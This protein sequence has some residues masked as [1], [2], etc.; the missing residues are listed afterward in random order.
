MGGG[1]E[2]PRRRI[3]STAKAAPPIPLEPVDLL[4]GLAPDVALHADELPP[5]I[6][7]DAPQAASMTAADAGKLVRAGEGTI[8]RLIRTR[9]LEPKPRPAAPDEAEVERAGVLPRT[10]EKPGE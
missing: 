9:V 5:G 2:K 7:T 10:P 3:R 8:R 1:G 6:E 4:A